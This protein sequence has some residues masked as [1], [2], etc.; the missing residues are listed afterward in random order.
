MKT[1]EEIK[2][3]WGKLIGFTER[4]KSYNDGEK[5]K[6]TCIIQKKI[7]EVFT[8]IKIENSNYHDKKPHYKIK[9]PETFLSNIENNWNNLKFFFSIRQNEE[10]GV[11]YVTKTIND[12]T[13]NV[14][15][16][17][18]VTPN[19]YDFY[20]ANTMSYLSQKFITNF[21]DVVHIL[22]V[23]S[24]IVVISNYNG[25]KKIFNS[26]L[27]EKNRKNII[28]IF[29]KQE[30]DNFFSF[31]SDFAEK[32]EY[33]QEIN[34]ILL[35]QLGGINDLQNRAMQIIESGDYRAMFYYLINHL[36]KGFDDLIAKNENYQ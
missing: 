24:H 6:R 10:I 34:Q 25:D 17:F 33:N 31:L 27:Q 30:N 5:I 29:K 35:Q 4:E 12:K 3:V 9:N 18:I 8:N 26:I 23:V 32:I 14:F 13:K 7:N 21:L 15:R 19:N 16:N 22:K 28:D 11:V 36:K 2:T 20:L 1:Q